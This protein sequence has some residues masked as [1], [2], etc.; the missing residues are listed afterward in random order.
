MSNYFEFLLGRKYP[1]SVLEDIRYLVEENQLLRQLLWVRHGCFISNLY[2]DDGEMQCNKCMIDFKRDSAYKIKQKFEQNASK[3]LVK[4][5]EQSLCSSCTKYLGVSHSY[6]TGKLCKEGIL[7]SWVEGL[8]KVNCK[9]YK[10]KE[11]DKK[12]Q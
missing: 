12:K 3:A 4:A 7:K 5:I 1:D 10:K 6:T 11:I 8:S 9:Y 2:G